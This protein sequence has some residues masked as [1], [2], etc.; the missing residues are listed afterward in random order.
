VVDE[1]DY[2]VLLGTTQAAWAPI[3]L[4]LELPTGQVELVGAPLGDG[5]ERTLPSG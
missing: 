2:P 3:D 5:A 4:R 1:L